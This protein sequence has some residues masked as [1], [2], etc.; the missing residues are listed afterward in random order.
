MESVDDTGSSTLV[1]LRDCLQ[2]LRSS[3]R[4]EERQQKWIRTHPAPFMGSQASRWRPYL[5]AFSGCHPVAPLA[6]MSILSA[7][8]PEWA[9]KWQTLI[10]H[11]EGQSSK[12][13]E[14]C[15]DM[16]RPC[17][18]HTHNQ[19]CLRPTTFDSFVNFKWRFLQKVEM[20]TKGEESIRENEYNQQCSHLA[21]FD[22]DWRSSLKCDQL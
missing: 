21:D 5:L 14:C 12:A 10:N 3:K 17:S 20:R 6:L 9:T 1:E 16:I 19:F 11:F 13:Q 7:H 15:N 22:K 2:P 18:A 8:L 4:D